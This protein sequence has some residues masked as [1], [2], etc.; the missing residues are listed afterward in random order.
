MKDVNQRWEEGTEHDSRSVALF[1]ELRRIDFKFGQDYF[2]FKAGGDGDNGEQL[3]YLL[4]IYY[5]KLD[6]IK[7][8]TAISP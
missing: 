6:K 4:D 5:E 1:E 8:P 3:M 7:C 2:D